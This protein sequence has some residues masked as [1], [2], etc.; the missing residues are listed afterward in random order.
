[1][2]RYT[3]SWLSSSFSVA[4]CTR[5]PKQKKSLNYMRGHWNCIHKFYLL[6][7]IVCST[8]LQYIIHASDFRNRRSTCFIY[9]RCIHTISYPLCKKVIRPGVCEKP[10]MIWL[11]SRRHQAVSLFYKEGNEFIIISQPLPTYL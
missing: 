10:A 1:M 3:K 5:G 11:A 9:P 7:K 8:S 2:L 6:M 4:L